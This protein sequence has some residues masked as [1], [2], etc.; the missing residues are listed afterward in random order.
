MDVCK[1]K[2]KQIDKQFETNQRRLNNHGDRIKMIER[3]I[4]GQKKDTT[5]LQEAI[6]SLKD[7]IDLLIEEIGG[8]KS[9]PLEKYEKA[10]W[11]VIAAVI[12][13]L[14]AAWF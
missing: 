2:H 4:V 14:V 6:K 5:H 12:G 1:E 11:L 7:S 10:G 9:K 3:D 8:L 13:Y